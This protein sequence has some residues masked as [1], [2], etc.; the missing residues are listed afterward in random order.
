MKYKISRYLAAGLV[1]P[2]IT[3]VVEGFAIFKDTKIY[4]YTQ[5]SILIIR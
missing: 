3:D 2:L 5:L 4:L 1:K